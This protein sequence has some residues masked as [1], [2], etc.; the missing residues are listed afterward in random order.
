[1]AVP[2]GNHST[3]STPLPLSVYEK[4][5]MSPALLIA[6]ASLW[7]V[8]PTSGRTMAFPFGNHSTASVGVKP[9]RVYE[10]E[11]PTMSLALLIPSAKLERN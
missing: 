4:P 6:H 10:Y 8:P 11:L 3:A 1:M 7:P 9:E 5:T 2:F